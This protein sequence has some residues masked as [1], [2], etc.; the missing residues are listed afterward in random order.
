MPD[1]DLRQARGETPVAL[2][3]VPAKIESA[4]YTPYNWRVRH[5][6]LVKG[7]ILE[8]EMTE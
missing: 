4:D 2:R 3:N 1:A 8:F 7:G 5:A 6:D